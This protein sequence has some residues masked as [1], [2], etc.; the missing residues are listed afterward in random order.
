[1]DLVLLLF[2]IFLIVGGHLVP[3]AICLLAYAIIVSRKR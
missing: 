2:G 1:M 3:G